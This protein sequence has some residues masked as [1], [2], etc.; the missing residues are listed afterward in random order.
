MKQK[1]VIYSIALAVLI[2]V[3]MAM[4]VSMGSVSIP[5]RDVYTILLGGEEA[6]HINEA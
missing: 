2:V 1:G 4:N 6:T 5:L 3:L